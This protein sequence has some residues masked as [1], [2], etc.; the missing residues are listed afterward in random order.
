MT[1]DQKT[2]MPYNTRRKSLSLPS[3][4]IHLPVTHASRA[5]AR[6]S[7]PSAGP[8][9]ENPPSKK[10][11][12]SHEESPSMSPPPK[13]APLKYENTPPPSPEAETDDL[14][15]VKPR[16]ID[17]EGINDEIVEGVIVLLQKTGNRPHLVKELAA[18]LSQSVK[19]VEQSANPSAIISSR[20]SSYLKRPWTALAPCPVAKELETVHP[21]RTY[22]YLTTYPHQPI[23]DTSTV[24]FPSRAIISPSISS[25]AS[26][27]D[28][29]D[30]ERRRELSPSPEVDLSSP[31]FEDDDMSTPPTPTGSFSGRPTEAPRNHRASSPPLEKDE[32]EFTQTARGM[33]KRKLSADIQM[34][35]VPSEMT[36][37]PTKSLEAD[38]LF[39]EAR[40]LNVLNSSV[41][42]SSPAMKPTMTAL[43]F[44]MMKRPFEDSHE[45]WTEASTEWDMRSPENVELEELDGMFDDF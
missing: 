6:V 41:F 31:E 27:S 19:I 12:R 25:A 32:K 40:N 38:S 28:E 45:V 21:R 8:N 10:L 14:D 1:S 33:Q 2:N 39:G 22:F 17:L 5:A 26:R 42:T 13:R 29:A 20:L 11:K 7:P 24:H 44:S 23:P 3:L 36:D 43:S 35:G 18:I 34:S 4:G 16:E 37:H 15:E 9:S 30:A